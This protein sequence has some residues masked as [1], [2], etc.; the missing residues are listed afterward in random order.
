MALFF[1]NFKSQF[2]TLCKEKIDTAV[3]AANQVSAILTM[4]LI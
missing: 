2:F 3:K 4:P 1:P